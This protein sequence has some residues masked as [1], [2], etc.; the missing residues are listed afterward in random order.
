MN[1]TLTGHDD[2]YAV[3]QLLMALFP[4]GAEGCAESALHRGT[5]WLTAVTKITYGG[6]TATA[7]RRLKASDE[8]VRLRRRTL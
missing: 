8:S 4:A 6:R 5:T 2:R 1:L 3:E 7:A